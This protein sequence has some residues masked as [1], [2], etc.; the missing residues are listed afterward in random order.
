MEA[1][2]A[3]E[4]PDFRVAALGAL[5]VGLSLADEPLL[6]QCLGDR[7]R[8]TRQQAQQLLACLPES[9]LAQ[10]MRARAET[11]LLFKRGLLSRQIEVVLPEAF[12]PKW[13]ADAIEEK[14]PAGVG[15]KAHWIRQIL[16]LVPVGHWL[17]R[18]SLAAADLIALAQKSEWSEVLIDAWLHALPLGTPPGLA[19]ALFESVLVAPKQAPVGSAASE[20][21]AQLFAG[22][23]AAER[24]TLTA[25][26]GG[27]RGLVWWCV[28][29]LGASPSRADA[30]AVLR[31]LA[32][33]LRDGTAPGGSPAAVAAARAIPPEL[34]E[35]AGMLLQ[36]DNGLSKP[37][38]HFLQALDVRAAMHA[39]FAPHR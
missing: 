6:T 19:A 13:K 12:D 5:E 14:P 38:E 22:C 3:E 28:P 17:G 39:A 8:E 23:T 35:E 21:V 18:F 11:I 27:E 36:R 15:E 30:R 20:R 4:S 32:P 29:H 26:H 7:R 16:A 1:S 2:W 10:R 31:H 25:Q 37:A 9:G 34:R 24:W 33:A